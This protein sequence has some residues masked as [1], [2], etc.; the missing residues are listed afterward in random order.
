MP[1]CTLELHHVAHDY[2]EAPP[3][4]R[5]AGF[6]LLAWRS[7]NIIERARTTIQLNGF[8]E[9]CLSLAAFSDEIT[10]FEFFFV[11]RD[12]QQP[13]SGFNWCSHV[14]FCQKRDLSHRRKGALCFYSS[15]AAL[16]LSLTRNIKKKWRDTTPD[17]DVDKPWR[18]WWS[19]KTGAAFYVLFMEKPTKE[20]R[21][22][23]WLTTVCRWMW[24]H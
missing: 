6:E 8:E 24:E 14:C 12:R 23:Q 1:T 3:R 16:S 17:A 20:A 11:D 19:V 5:P 2:W 9:V 13:R 22:T 7:I 4:W 10:G 21:T 15:P 18:N